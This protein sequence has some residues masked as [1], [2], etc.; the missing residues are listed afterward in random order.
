MRRLPVVILILSTSVGACT[1]NGSEGTGSSPVVVR[2]SSSPS[3]TPTVPPRP[4]PKHARVEGTYRV[5]FRQIHTT[6]GG[7]QR[8]VTY[9]RWKI[10]PKCKRG[11]C[12]I[13]VIAKGGN[14]GAKYTAR[15]LY[16]HGQYR[17][18]RHVGA[19]WTCTIGSSTRNLSANADYVFRATKVRLVHDEWVAS[20][21]QGSWEAKA[22]SSCGFLPTAEERDLIRASLQ[23]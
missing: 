1:S 6:V 15:G 20:K 16:V 7:A 9:N 18:N 8:R 4:N 21:L 5:V 10:T 22:T 3:P 17:F 12:D 11:P 13:L 19:L 2:S 23:S 14:G